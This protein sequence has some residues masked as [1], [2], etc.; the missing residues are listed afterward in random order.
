LNQPA[1]IPADLII[2]DDA[3]TLPTRLG[4]LVASR[5]SSDEVAALAGPSKYDSITTTIAACASQYLPHPGYHERLPL[6]S[7]VSW[8]DGERRTNSWLA[9]LAEQGDSGRLRERIETLCR[10]AVNEPANTDLVH[11][12]WLDLWYDEGGR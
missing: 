8:L 6:Q 9:C 1:P 4:E 2:V 11:A 7:F 10:E 5:V 12:H 3:G